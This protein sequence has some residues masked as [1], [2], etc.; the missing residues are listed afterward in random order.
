MNKKYSEG[1]ES[2]EGKFYVGED[3]PKSF[4]RELEQRTKKFAVAIIKLSAEL[5]NTIEGRIVRNQLTKAGTSIGANY[6]EAN[7]A[8]SRADFKSKIKVCE[9]ESSE[10]DYWL[11][12]IIEMSWITLKEIEFEVTEC[13]ELLAIFTS[14]GKNLD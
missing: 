9:S 5:P 8:R 1:D 4:A 10:T 12:I 3:N 14:I 2:Q 6:R 13:R 7:R 11:G